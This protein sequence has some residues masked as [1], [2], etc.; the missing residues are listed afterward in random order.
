MRS[1]IIRLRRPEA[2]EQS[3][4]RVVTSDETDNEIVVTLDI[5][6]VE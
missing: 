5:L 1:A 6:I 4:Q 2:A 3:F